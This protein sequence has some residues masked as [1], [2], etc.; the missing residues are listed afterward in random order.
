LWGIPPQIIIPRGT[1]F[2]KATVYSNAHTMYWLCVSALLTRHSRVLEVGC[3]LSP[4][5]I[6][7]LE[8]VL[9]S[10]KLILGC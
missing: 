10:L 7:L 9:L 5:V 2:S 1:I 8:I 6:E 4:E 3:V